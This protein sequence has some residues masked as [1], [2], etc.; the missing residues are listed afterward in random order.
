MKLET[1]KIIECLIEF[2]IDLFSSKISKKSGKHR[3]CWKDFKAS[4]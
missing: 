2:C 3:N 1:L 4:V